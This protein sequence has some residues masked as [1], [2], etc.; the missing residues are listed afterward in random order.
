M[1][2]PKQIISRP[3]YANEEDIKALIRTKVNKV[4]EAYVSIYIHQSDILFLSPDKTPLDKLEKPLLTLK[5]KSISLEN[6]NLFVHG[7]STYHY[8]Q[9]RL[10]EN[11][12]SEEL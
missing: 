12:A 4:N 8:R 5:N 6:I 7:S 10:V 2:L 11:H 9:G 3:I 1:N